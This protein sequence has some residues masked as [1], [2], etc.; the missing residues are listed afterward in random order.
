MLLASSSAEK[1]EISCESVQ[2]H[3][4]FLFGWLEISCVSENAVRLKLASFRL[5][6]KFYR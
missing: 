4:L 6:S 1:S 5:L 2:L 3:A